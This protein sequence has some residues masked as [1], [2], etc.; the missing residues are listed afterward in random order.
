M[1]KHPMLEGDSDGQS[2]LGATYQKKF[3]QMKR[4][5]EQV[6]DFDRRVAL[7]ET[8]ET[9]TSIAERSVSKLKDQMESSP[10]PGPTPTQ[11]EAMD[12]LEKMNE[13]VQQDSSG[14]R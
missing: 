14:D 1:S 7:E 2:A 5:I 12:A 6:E 13:S 11:K 4:E 8:L 3:E 10:E 9:I